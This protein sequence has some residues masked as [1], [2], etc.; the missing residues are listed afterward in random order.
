MT[1]SIVARCPRT[2]QLG[3]AVA[4]ASLACGAFAPS[5]Q[6]NTGAIASQ[7]FGNPF[8][9]IDGLRLLAD[10]LT[11]DQVVAELAAADPGRDLRQLLVVDAREGVAAFTGRECIPWAGHQTGAGYVAGGNTLA[12][13]Q[14]VSAMAA[15]FEE[16]E[17]E[18]LGERLVRTPEAGEAAGGDRRGRQ[19][20]ALLVAYDQD[21]RYYDLRVDHHPT[22][23]TELRLIFELRTAD[24]ARWGDFRPT[25]EAPL[26][27][28][29]LEAWSKIKATHELEATGKATPA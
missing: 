2:G 10:G 8:F 27:P 16:A 25:R 7:A 19:S 15:A 17:H 24:R 21:Y 13:S 29:F 28:G 12:G 20:A 22:P 11:P 3:V 23:V 14:V 26:P 5:V 4:S 18:E 9:G 1:F 6:A